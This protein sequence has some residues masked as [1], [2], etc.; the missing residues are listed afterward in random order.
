VQQIKQKLERSTFSR[1]VCDCKA[2]IH[3]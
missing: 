2:R 1:Q 3:S